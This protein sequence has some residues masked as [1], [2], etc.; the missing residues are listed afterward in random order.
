MFT[1]NC[2]VHG[3]MY[4][5]IKKLFL[6]EKVAVHQ[7]TVYPVHLRL[8][9]GADNLQLIC[10][11]RM[12]LALKLLLDQGRSNEILIEVCDDRAKKNQRHTTNEKPNMH[13]DIYN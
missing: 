9:F 4:S 8:G 1:F 11:R 2:S 5:N 13:K 12:P 6:L 3:Y 7:S 10:R